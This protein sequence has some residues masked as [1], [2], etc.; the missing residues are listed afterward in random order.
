MEIPFTQKI[1]NKKEK[2]R[3]FGI[4]APETKQEWGLEAKEV[5]NSLIAGK[6]VLLEIKE[7]DKYDRILAVVYLN[8][9]NINLK[10]I[11]TGNALFR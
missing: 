2:I 3:M 8:K 4:D 11:E 1:N 10:M 7:R 9:I 6:E 5:L